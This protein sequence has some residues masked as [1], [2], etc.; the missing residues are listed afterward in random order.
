MYP[1]LDETLDRWIREVAP[2]GDLTCMT[3]GLSCQPG[4]L[5]F[6]A[7]EETVVCGSEEAARIF[8]KCGAQ[9]EV[10]KSTGHLAQPG[11]ILMTAT[12][13]VSALHLA[14]KVAI[15]IL[16]YG[17]GI[18]TRTRRLIIKA[19]SSSSRPRI[20]ATCK[21][22]PGTKELSA[23]AVLAG[24]GMLHRLGLSD[25]I[26]IFDHHTV[27]FPSFEDLVR[28]VPEW[29]SRACERKIIAE[30]ASLAH[31]EALAGAGVDGVQ[32]D[33]VP[34]WELACNV[35]RL[36]TLHPHLLVIAA[37]GVTESNVAEL[38]AT[39]VDVLATSAVYFGKPADIATSIRPVSAG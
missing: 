39:G 18:A 33:K 25:S 6:T 16:E 5:T 24:G 26:L 8:K 34:A 23:K 22:F 28:M 27:F 14:W 29:K 35:Q 36:R 21:M 15:N 11:E 20:A 38:A 7:R 32:F 9:A 2:A 30:V 37:G 1:I 17:S 12:G 10:L 3:L 13:P 31:A 19:S 4:A